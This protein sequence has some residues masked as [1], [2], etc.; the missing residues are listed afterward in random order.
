MV[1][2]VE[3][4]EMKI[5][6]RKNTATVAAVVYLIRLIMALMVKMAA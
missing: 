6:Q 3:D 2:V 5:N 4:W 1:L